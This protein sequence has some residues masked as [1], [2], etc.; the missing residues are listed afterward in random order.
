MEVDM[1]HVL[2]TFALFSFCAVGFAAE[3]MD[4]KI[5][6]PAQADEVPQFSAFAHNGMLY[7]TVLGDCNS[8]G[9]SLEVSPTCRQDRVTKNRAVECDAK[10]AVISTKMACPETPPTA[11]VMAIN[12]SQEKVASE[13]RLLHLGYGAQTIDVRLQ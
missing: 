10:L 4:K 3:K 9:G 5:R 1:K 13:A 2:L 12:L 7:V 11:K 6:G 8:Y